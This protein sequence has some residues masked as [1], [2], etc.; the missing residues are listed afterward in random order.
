MRWKWGGERERG[1]FCTIIHNPLAFVAFFVVWAWFRRA[2]FFCFCF[3]VF[4]G[5]VVFML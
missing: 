4:C 5:F 1:V 2:L 3:G